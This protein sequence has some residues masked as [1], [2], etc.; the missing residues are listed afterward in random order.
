MN[1]NATDTVCPNN[2]DPAFHQSLRKKAPYI[3]RGL[4]V[5]RRGL[6]VQIPTFC[7]ATV[8]FWRDHYVGDRDTVDAR[9][10]ALRDLVRG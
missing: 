8:H 9:C 1:G 6:R 4:R 2:L 3:R 5:I 10:P 7:V